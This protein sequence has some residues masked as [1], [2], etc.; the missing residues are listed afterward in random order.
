[1][2][3]A[4]RRHGFHSRGTH[5]AL[6][7]ARVHPQ[8]SRRASPARMTHP[9]LY[10]RPATRDDAVQ[11]L[12][13]TGAVPLGGGTDLLVTIAEDLSRPDVLVDLRHLPDS[14]TVA[15]TKDGVRIGASVRIA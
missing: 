8:A 14:R 7:R 6:V 1:H 9:F 2:A 4:R 12:A 5:H 3:G 11:Q 15:E 10:R 13:V